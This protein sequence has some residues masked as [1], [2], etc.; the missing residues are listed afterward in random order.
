MSK[1]VK[2]CH[3]VSASHNRNDEWKKERIETKKIERNVNK[4]TD[5]LVVGIPSRE[6]TKNQ[7][8]RTWRHIGGRQVNESEAREWGRKSQ[9]KRKQ[10]ERNRCCSKFSDSLIKIMFSISFG[11][12]HSGS[13]LLKF[14]E[15]KKMP[16]TQGSFT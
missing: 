13:K 2:L 8:S 3:R 15:K 6:S 12:T 10:K 1:T 9:V 11:F 7:E 14:R 16:F 4:F 5:Y